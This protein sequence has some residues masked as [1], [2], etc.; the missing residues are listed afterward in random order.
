MSKILVPAYRWT[1]R[2]TKWVEFRREPMP[3]IQCRRGGSGGWL[4]HPATVAERRAWYEALDQEVKPRGRR[5]PASLPTNWDD[6]Q[7]G[8]YGIRNWKKFRKTQWR[9]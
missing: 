3:G 1:R 5:S 7:R 2:N 8:D 6:I 9:I 4:R